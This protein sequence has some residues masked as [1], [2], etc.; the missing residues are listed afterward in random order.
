MGRHRLLGIATP[1]GLPQ[2]PQ[3]CPGGSASARDYRPQ[4]RRHPAVG[5]NRLIEAGKARS[6]EAS[7][8]AYLAAHEFNAAKYD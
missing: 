5:A 6:R 7:E 1:M 2:L 4:D 8:R 3:P